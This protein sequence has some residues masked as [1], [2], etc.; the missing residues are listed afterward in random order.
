MKRSDSSLRFRKQLAK[1]YD[2]PQIAN[3]IP[4]EKYFSMARTLHEVALKA[5]AQGDLVLSY[6]YLH[7]FVTLVND[8]IPTHNAYRLPAQLKNRIWS[9][10]VLNSVMNI[11]EEVVAKMDQLMDEQLQRQVDEELCDLFDGNGTGISVQPAA[12]PSTPD[13]TAILNGAIIAPQQ[14]R[15]LSDACALLRDPEYNENTISANVE[16]ELAPTEAMYPNV[17]SLHFINQNDRFCG[18]TVPDIEILKRIPDMYNFP[19]PPPYVSNIE[20]KIGSHLYVFQDFDFHV[21]FNNFLKNLPMELQMARSAIE[22]NRCFFLHLGVAVNIHPFVL[23]VAFRNIA[24]NKLKDIKEGVCLMSI[25]ALQFIHV[26][27]Y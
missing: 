22:V 23:Q 7:N 13:S 8:R 17:D 27:L 19:I 21:T 5:V 9:S 14:I 2:V 3:F 24:A 11:L 26:F 12:H 15:G 4:I 16:D 25:C 6:K 10:R 1:N 20:L 18:V